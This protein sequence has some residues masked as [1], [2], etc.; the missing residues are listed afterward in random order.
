MDRDRRS[1]QCG[2]AKL[3]IVFLSNQSCLCVTDSLFLVLQEMRRSSSSSKDGGGDDGNTEPVA[4]CG[5][6]GVIA[7]NPAQSKHLETA[8]M[9]V[10]GLDVDFCNLRSETSY[11]EH[12]RIPQVEFGSPL[13]DSMRRD[14]TINALYYNLRSRRIEDYTRRGIADLVAGKIVTPID[15]VATF[16][17]DPLRVLRAIRFAV[18]YRFDLEQD[19]REAAQLPEIHKALHVKV[20]RERVGKELD[21]MLS[22]SK[23]GCSPCPVLALRLISELKLAG[24]VFALPVVGQDKVAE[25]Y[26]PVVVV[27]ADAAPAG[28]D[29]GAGAAAAGGGSSLGTAVPAAAAAAAAAA[30]KEEGEPCSSAPQVQMYYHGSND[31]P[32]ARHIRELGWEESRRYLRTLPLVLE[33]FAPSSPST[34]RSSHV[35]DAMIDRRLLP[36]AAFLLPF[37]ELRYKLANKP[38]KSWLACT[39]VF[40]EGIKFKNKDCQI[41]TTLFETLDQML[42]F[43]TD[44]YHAAALVNT[45]TTNQNRPPASA[46]MRLNAGLLL[47][48]AKEMWVTSLLLATVYKMRQS[49]GTTRE[50]GGEAT[51]V[52]G[53]T[54]QTKE[55]DWL[56]VAVSVYDTIVALDLD[57][58]WKMKPLL[59]GKAIQQSLGLPR[60]PEVGT[61]LDEQVKWMLLNPDGTAQQ[62][63]E[64]L[65][66]VKRRID[67]ATAGTDGGSGEGDGG[68]GGSTAMDDSHHGYSAGTGTTAPVIAAPAPDKDRSSG[69]SGHRKDSISGV[70]IEKMEIDSNKNYNGNGD[71]GG[72]GDDHRDS[73]HFSKK[74]HVESMDVVEE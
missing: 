8:T 67:E 24:S 18:R 73:K 57:G 37:R 65:M 9:R 42:A 56:D 70:D 71:G 64:H 26:G 2:G 14:F 69:S 68:G 12:S 59:N 52:A 23:K 47:R 43:L 16:R 28:N 21:G 74:M 15:P 29:L 33:R 44:H 46:S 13:E 50:G 55:V 49:E 60:G 4:T 72:G 34:S 51:A 35:T 53:T 6:M 31:S 5:R 40:K 7:A 45:A 27:A 36:L 3:A 38:D 11:E 20:S 39:F 41:A 10:A 25:V 1:L 48:T 66:S 61:Y 32:V 22:S 62:C 54:T 63:E 30:A 19:L 17:D 58:V